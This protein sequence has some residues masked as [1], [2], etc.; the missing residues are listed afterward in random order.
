MASES[1]VTRVFAIRH[2][3]REDHINLNWQKLSKRPHDA[4]LSR[5]GRSQAYE[6]G[7]YLASVIGENE[8]VT[9]YSSPLVRCVMTAKLIIN[10]FEE[11]IRSSNKPS[12]RE[13]KI[14][15]E[16]GIAETAWHLRNRMLGIHDDNDRICPFTNKQR[17]CSGPVLLG[18][19]DLLEAAFPAEIDMDY[20]SCYPLRYNKD[21]HEIDQSTAKPYENPETPSARVKFSVP[22]ILA[23]EDNQEVVILVSHGGV[24]REST[25]LLLGAAK[26]ESIG[27]LDTFALTKSTS[28][29]HF[30]GGSFKLESF[31]CPEEFR[32]DKTGQKRLD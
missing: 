1:R 4:P 21:G 25:N 24:I 11:N 9:I 26:C 31:W 16:E 19:G 5:S 3:E 8:G 18:P 6:C 23:Q 27:Y 32:G 13:L 30:H 10:G 12:G 17:I 15:I 7:E 28:K 20:L 29:S 2:G 14:R 22:K